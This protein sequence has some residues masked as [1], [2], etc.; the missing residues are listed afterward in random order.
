MKE[1]SQKPGLGL[2]AI[3][4]I[5]PFLNSIDEGTCRMDYTSSFYW[6]NDHVNVEIGRQKVQTAKHER[7]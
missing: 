1:F 5:F 4:I 7:E 3:I 2:N 6:N